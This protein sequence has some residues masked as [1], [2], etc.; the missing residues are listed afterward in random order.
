MIMA[1]KHFRTIRFMVALNVLDARGV[2]ANDDIKREII[3]EA[4]KFLLIINACNMGLGEKIVSQKMLM[5][6]K[7]L[8]SILA[9]D[10]S[11]THPELFGEQ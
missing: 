1:N 4:E 11:I 10:N 2:D 6:K 5:S 8:E 3:Y 7:Y 9:K